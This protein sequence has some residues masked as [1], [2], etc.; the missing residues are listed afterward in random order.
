[1]K[2]LTPLLVLLALFATGCGSWREFCSSSPIVVII[3]ERSSHDL[4]IQAW[5]A[6]GNGAFTGAVVTV[7]ATDSRSVTGHDGWTGLLRT[8]ANAQWVSIV[9]E[10]YDRDGYAHSYSRGINLS[11]Q[12]VTEERVWVDSTPPR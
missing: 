7:L 9:V 11:H 3:E 10:W 1:M 4:R 2:K 8:P 12:V 5:D 6:R